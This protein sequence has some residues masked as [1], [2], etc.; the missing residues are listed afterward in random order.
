MKGG[1]HLGANRHTRMVRTV[2]CRVYAGDI[3]FSHLLDYI[4]VGINSKSVDEHAG[5]IASTRGIGK[6]KGNTESLMLPQSNQVV[7]DEAYRCCWFY[8]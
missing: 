7:A 5:Y 8:A 3:P 4:L 6:I 1:W 2:R